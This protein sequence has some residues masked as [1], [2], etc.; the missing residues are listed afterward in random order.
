MAARGACSWAVAVVFLA[1]LAG[2]VAPSSALGSACSLSADD[3]Y[4]GACGPRFVGADVGRRGRLGRTRRSTRRSGWPTST[5]TGA[6]SCSRATTRASRCGRSTPASGSGARRSTPMTCRRSLT[7][8]R[9]PKPGEDAGDGLDASPQYS[10]TIRLADVDGRARAT[11]S[12]RRFADGM[13]DLQVHAAGG[14]DRASTAV[15][16]R[17]CGRAAHSPTRRSDTRTRRSYLPLGVDPLGQLD[18]TGA[19]PTLLVAQPT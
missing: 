9:S 15:A 19:H 10:S 13:H 4:I 5:A 11:R 17:C 2:V 18:Q 12:W 1:A 16:G 14:H 8:F 7:D 3:S 6:T